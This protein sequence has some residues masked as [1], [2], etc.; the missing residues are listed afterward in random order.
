MAGSRNSL[1]LI[2][3]REFIVC[4]W[5]CSTSIIDEYIP[6]SNRSP[7][8]EVVLYQRGAL[9]GEVI[10]RSLHFMGWLFHYFFFRPLSFFRV[11][12]LPGVNDRAM[13]MDLKTILSLKR[14][15]KKK[16]ICLGIFFYRI[17]FIYFSLGFISNVRLLEKL[18]YFGLV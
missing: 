14:K 17:T 7:L 3:V 18:D 4:S 12:L 9:I 11:L 15:K 1:F 10:T 13:W 8:C 6:P 2:I 16:I 5:R